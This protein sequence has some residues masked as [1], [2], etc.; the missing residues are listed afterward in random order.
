M[1]VHI[2]GTEYQQ[3]VFD[4][5]KEIN[6]GLAGG[7]IATQNL[8]TGILT[9]TVFDNDWKPLTE[10]ITFINN[11]EY[12]FHPSLNVKKLGLQK[13]GKNE[14]EIEVPDS[15]YAN[16]SIAVTDGAIA[17]DKSNNIISRS[18]VNRRIKGKS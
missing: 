2:V 6:K 14:F 18:F 12:D 17:A 5:T 13:H 15:L 7:V 9:I 1:Q 10:R 8:P 11:G 16:L 4:I 3:P